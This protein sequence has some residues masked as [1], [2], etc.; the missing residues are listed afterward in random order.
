MYRQLLAVVLATCLS[1]ALPAIEL[2]E[3][4]VDEAYVSGL[5][6]QVTGF[7]WAPGGRMF[8]VEKAGIVRVA[9]DGVLQAEPFLD[10][11]SI[12]NDRVDRGMLS[13]AVHPQFPQQ[14]YIYV[15]YTYDPPELV[16]SGFTGPGELDGNGNR[17]ARLVRYTADKNQNYNRALSGSATV[18]LGKN[19][20]FANI[21]DPNGK[22]DTAIPSCGPIGNPVRDCLPIDEMSHTI[23][24]LRFAPDGMLFVSNG[25]G[26]SY[27]SIEE[28]TVMVQD[29]DSLRGKVLRIDP[30]T[31]NGLPDNPFYD[32][33]PASNRSRVVN[34]GL[35]NPYSMTIH[36]ETGVPYV[37][38]VG[39]D[40]WEEING[41]YGKNF[42]WPCYSGGNGDN[43][44]RPGFED[45]PFCQQFY[46]DDPDIEA[47]VLSW[48]H[49]D[50]ASAM[51]GDFYFGEQFPEQ[52]RGKLFYADFLQ[53]WIRYA[54]VDDST[55]ITE[56]DFAE[57]VLPMVEI[58]AGADGSLYY[59]SI[60]SGEVRRIRYTGDAGAS[61]NLTPKAVIESSVEA[62]TAPLEVRFSAA[63]SVD[64][65]GS[66]V[67][68]AWD[69]ADGESSGEQNPVHV[70]K[71]AGDYAVSLTVKDNRGAENIARK[72]IRVSADT[73]DIGFSRTDG[74]SAYKVGDK[75]VL[76]AEAGASGVLPDAEQLL[77]RVVFVGAD[78]ISAE[79]SAGRGETFNFSYP[80]HSD[81]LLVRVCLSNAAASGE[82][83]AYCEEL[84]K[85]TAK[86]LLETYPAGLPLLYEDETITTPFSTRVLIGGKRRLT[87]PAE[88]DSAV[89]ARWSD[90]GEAEREITMPANDV[91]LVA[92]F[93]VQESLVAYTDAFSADEGD[94]CVSETGCW[95]F[96]WNPQADFSDFAKHQ[97]LALQDGYFK[98]V[99][100]DSN[101]YLGKHTSHAGRA[102]ADGVTHAEYAVAAFQVAAGGRY[103]ITASSLLDKNASCG[104]GLALQ[105]LVDSEQHKQI[106]VPP[107]GSAGFDTD[108]G[109]L[110]PGHTV[111]I[112]LDPKA[113]TE[114]D[115]FAWD[116]ALQRQ[117]G[118]EAAPEFSDKA[119]KVIFGRKGERIVEDFP[120]SDANGDT[121]S[122]TAK[123]LPKGLA[124]DGKTG[125]VS[126]T[127]KQS[128]VYASVIS[129]SDGRDEV[130]HEV[131][132]EITNADG[133]ID[134]TSS[135]GGSGAMSL[136]LLLLP[137][138]VF[139]RRFR[140]ARAA[141]R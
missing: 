27:N 74:K 33:D 28:L 78:G 139:Y 112:A 84:P 127:L 121:L 77:W 23:G 71:Q 76:K 32:G 98:P 72:T 138:L 128:A 67:S 88:V 79:H 133:S 5:P 124:I 59:A 136:G 130:M 45:L 80:D 35:R 108:L 86:L 57:D 55:N 7:D 68:Y 119:A 21:G 46:L 104:D 60:V 123:N 94:S 3:N 101:L 125:Q 12:V 42:A 82:E 73:A 44:R 62:G 134:K 93:A 91:R 31:G 64:P 129:V 16:S 9:V 81:K 29:L 87:A 109:N 75:V 36:P 39:W 70:F 95:G 34:Y 131:R 97:R 140:T 48:P 106:D 105:V 96:F 117:A 30:E 92:S 14:P 26:A 24:A 49:Q 90:Q 63:G 38:D 4:F 103:Q 47:P 107:G 8:I 135:G 15:L 56:Y 116:F 120:A 99:D 111:R 41:G 102:P 66:I 89:F 53:G 132:W 18:I 1:S 126:G 50:G 122:W 54:D 6:G 19:S 11:Q 61:D 37:G 115:T 40:L 25:D 113:S 85:S 20:T 58:R 2:P 17:V 118:A 83:G 51:V 141:V 52:Y 65:D 13:V 114:C 69:F 137:G 22:Y 10:I 100:S 110:K 43:L